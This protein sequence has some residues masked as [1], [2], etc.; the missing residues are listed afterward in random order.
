M[1]PRPVGTRKNT[2]QST[3]ST[4]QKRDHCIDQL[5]IV[6]RDRRV[7]LDGYIN[8]AGPLDG[9]QRPVKRA[10]D[11]PKI[12]MNSRCGAIKADGKPGKTALFEPQ[13][14]FPRLRAEL[15]WA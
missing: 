13:D 15:H 8:L 6:P 10:W 11:T 12:I 4:F 14:C 1:E 9:F 2:L 5:Q 3:I 7:D